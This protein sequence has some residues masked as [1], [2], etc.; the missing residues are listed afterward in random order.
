MILKEY[1]SNNRNHFVAMQYFGLILNRTFLVLI[2]KEHLIGLKVNGIVGAKT[3]GLPL[4]SITNLMA[5]TENLN[6]YK[7]YINKK[8]YS[9][10]EKLDIYGEQIIKSSCSNFKIHRDDIKCVTFN[11]EKKWGMANYPHDGRIYIETRNN[12]RKE[13]IIL[14]AQSGKYIVNLINNTL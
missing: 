10:L 2:T 8:Y 4:S 14:G 13:L 11:S 3:T 9:R 12:Q 1:I 7:S 6:D 5:I